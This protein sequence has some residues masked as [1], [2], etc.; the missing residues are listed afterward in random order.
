M[1]SFTDTRTFFSLIGDELSVLYHNSAPS[2]SATRTSLKFHQKRLTGYLCLVQDRAQIELSCYLGGLVLMN[3]LATNGALSSL[4]PPRA[5]ADA[6][7][8]VTFVCTMISSKQLEDSTYLN[9]DFAKVSSFIQL[10]DL[11]Q[12]E[13]AVLNGLGWHSIVDQPDIDRI[14]RKAD[15]VPHLVP[16]T[17]Q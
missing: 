17:A 10:R 11:N 9:R 2:V 3:R 8:A 4:L 16:V 7:A 12:L 15:V 5:S 1:N 13:L 6:F 14:L